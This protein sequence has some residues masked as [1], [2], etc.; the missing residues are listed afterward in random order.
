MASMGLPS[1]TL[2]DTPPETADEAYDRAFVARLHA[3]QDEVV[4]VRHEAW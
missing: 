3:R 1:I 2:P 4:D